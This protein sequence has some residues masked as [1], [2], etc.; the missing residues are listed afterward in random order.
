MN[1]FK[2]IIGAEKNEAVYAELISVCT[3]YN[4][5]QF[6][7]K[8]SAVDLFETRKKIINRMRAIE[9]ILLGIEEL[10]RWCQEDLQK[11]HIQIQDFEKAVKFE[12]SP[13]DFAMNTDSTGRTA[14][15]IG[16]IIGTVTGSAAAVWGSTAA[17]S[18]ATV[19]GTAST[20]TAIS[21]LSGVAATNAALA[22]LGGGS[23]AAGGAGVAG[24]HLV[25]AM[26]GPIGGAI[27]GASAIGSVAL[28]RSKNRK[29]LDEMYKQIG[30]II[31]DNDLIKPKLKHLDML[32]GR[33]K[34]FLGMELRD[35]QQWVNIV[36]PKNYKSWDDEQKHCLERLMNNLSYAAQ[37]INERV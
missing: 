30:T 7:F 24:G 4:C 34:N 19:L 10:P 15:V 37:I 26:F 29:R 25:L 9:V 22:W 3:E 28:M 33:S 1:I 5:N 32:V 14:A 31:H 17:M 23:I 20:G 12:N 11:I 13:R 35:S 27:A 8:Q 16:S 36:T 21:A 6:H 18:L 2:K